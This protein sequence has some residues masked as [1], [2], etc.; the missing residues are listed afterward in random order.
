LQFR[1]AT[2]HSLGARLKTLA[3]E[4]CGGRLLF[5]LEVRCCL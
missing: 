3:D 2:Y 4:L 1:S 5:L